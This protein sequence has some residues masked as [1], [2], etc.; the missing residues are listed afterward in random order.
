MAMAILCSLGISAAPCFSQDVAEA[1]KQE[2]ARKEEARKKS[3]RVYTE[4]DLKRAQ[5]L[6]PEDR[7]Q[8]EATKN[9]AARAIEEKSA[10]AAITNTI[11]DA[12]PSPAQTSLG[13]VARINRKKK[14]FRALERSAQFPLALS[15]ET[16]LASPKPAPSNLTPP[17]TPILPPA[18]KSP[19]HHPLLPG[20][21][22][23]RSPFER[24]RGHYFAPGGVASAPRPLA[25]RA[26]APAPR[27]LVP[28]QPKSA[29][30]RATSVPSALVEPI[31]PAIPAATPRGVAA[32]SADP[33]PGDL[34]PALASCVVVAASGDSLWKIAQHHLGRGQRW[35]E[36]LSANP[37]LADPNH[38]RVGERIHIPA[39][40]LRPT[41]DSHY[42]VQAGDSLS[43]IAA[44][45]FHHAAAWSCIA[46]ANPDLADANR[47]RTGQLLLLPASCTQ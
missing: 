33:S 5:I 40:E 45:Q 47:I 36:L 41:S 13:E 15:G 6:T 27:P 43:A 24:P 11:N 26:I 29:G 25:P 37:Q 42:R 16:S 10:A 2:R 9:P 46:D 17:L 4:E 32:N 3:K 30:P 23:R 35:Q 1:A 21:V 28:S 12:K 19:P 20:P 39:S 34:G 7:A 38:I 22:I 18:V 31:V 8:L 14:E 44:S